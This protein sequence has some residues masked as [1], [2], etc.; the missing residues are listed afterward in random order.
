[1]KTTTGTSHFT[2]RTGAENYYQAYCPGMARGNLEAYVWNKI[3]TGGIH[4][5]PPTLKPGQKLLVNQDEQ[6]YFIEETTA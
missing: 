1:M 6:R 4:I 3:K 2:N 5:G